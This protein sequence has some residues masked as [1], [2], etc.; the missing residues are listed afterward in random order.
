MPI[1]LS[2]IAAAL[3]ALLAPLPAS[4]QLFGAVLPQARTGPVGEARTVFATMTNTSSAAMTNCRPRL[5]STLTA[6]MT[7]S[8]QT[9]N[10][11]NQLTGSPDTPAIIGAGSSQGFVVALTP[12]VVRTG[13]VELEMVCDGATPGDVVHAPLDYSVNDMLLHAETAPGADIIPVAATPSGDGVMTIATVGGVQAMALAAV[14]IGATQTITVTP[15]EPTGSTILPVTLQVVETTSSGV[16]I[17]APAASV[18]VQFASGQTR[19]FGVL[20]SANPAAGIMFAPDTNR[21]VVR[22]T[23]VDG[24]VR[25][26]TSV[27][28][29]APGPAGTSPIGFYQAM[30]R[31]RIASGRPVPY[32]SGE[33]RLSPSLTVRFARLPYTKTDG[34]PGWQQFVIPYAVQTSGFAQTAVSQATFMNQDGV[35]SLFGT[36]VSAGTFTPNS[37][38]RSV[39]EGVSGNADE[40]AGEITGTYSNQN[41]LTASLSDLAGTY[42]LQRWAAGTSAQVPAGTVSISSGGVIAGT[43]VTPDQNTTCGVLG[44]VADNDQLANTLAVQVFSLIGPGSACSRS[45]VGVLIKRGLTNIIGG[46]LGGTTGDYYTM[47]FWDPTFSSPFGGVLHLR[48]N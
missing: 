35:E 3:L 5:P 46:G 38:F 7:L 29:Q 6:Q 48:R 20:A 19:F 8:Y 32:V 12:T 27:A 40:L 2:A 30:T 1:R 31:P 26:R 39:Y 22:F 16:I 23:G 41:F 43:Y 47:L 9:T 37:G 36:L 44:Q 33:V 15:G 34:S 17:G 13:P 24:R 45:A 4:A 21:V 25:G 14:N 28:I 42:A 18:Q 10:A 11:L